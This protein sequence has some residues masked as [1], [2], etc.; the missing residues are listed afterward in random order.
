MASKAP[1]SS[2]TDGARTPR[3]RVSDA[4][5]ACLREVTREARRNKG[6]APV[7]A[8]ALIRLYYADAADEDLSSRSAAALAAAALGHVRAGA[9]RR[10]GQPCV[11][12]FNPTLDAD[13]W[14]SDHTIVD[15]INDDMPFLVDSVSMAL[16]RLGHGIHLTVHPLLKVTRT[17]AGRLK[18][19][20]SN[21]ESSAVMESY[22]HLEITRETDPEVLERIHSTI[23][24]VLSDVRAT[25]EDWQ[26][27]VARLRAAS[28][29]L[30]YSAPPNEGILEESCALLDW[31]ADDHFTLLGYREYR[32]LRGTDED[33]LEP[34]TGTGL[35]ILRD[36]GEPQP[37]LLLTREMR[38][39]ARSKD[40]LILTKANTKSTVHRPAHLDYV[41]VK[42]FDEKGRAVAEKRFLGLLT[43]IAYS[44]SPQEIP[45]VRLKVNKVVQ[46]S[47]VDPRSHRG[48]ALQHILNNFPREE[49][50]QSPHQ[51]W[52]PQP[53]GSTKG[54]AVP[55]A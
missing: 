1:S 17:P 14:E 53:A 54:E 50:F 24:E 18:G 4:P 19:L 16:N 40:P 2:A 51:H 36:N 39:H 29:E 45:L 28:A 37:P 32:L 34:V 8:T 41:G 26:T 49:L 42:V 11:R 27:M 31:L 6:P 10:R 44:A 23:T 7:D 25:V 15:V 13:G 3:R 55:A 35:G 12:V 48:K 47:G 21:G 30:R 46:H 22:I 38:K 9:T 33:R 5:P 43:S 52:H 20:A